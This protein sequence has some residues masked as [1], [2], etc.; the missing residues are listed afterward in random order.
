[1]CYETKLSINLGSAS[2]IQDTITL[3]Q[4]IHNHVKQIEDA[5]NEEMKQYLSKKKKKKTKEEL[6]QQLNDELND[7]IQDIE[8]AEVEIDNINKKLKILEKK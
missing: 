4:V 7:W 1:M 8:G 5:K 6:I 2:D 3:L